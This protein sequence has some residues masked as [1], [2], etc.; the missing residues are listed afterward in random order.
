MM[1][2]GEVCE[3]V[4]VCVCVCVGREWGTWGTFKARPNFCVGVY[5][6]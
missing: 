5:V 1:G 2:F 3:S 4:S 6:G